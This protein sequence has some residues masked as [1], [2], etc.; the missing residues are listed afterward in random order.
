MTTDRASLAPKKARDTIG[1]TQE[2]FAN[3]KER[4]KTTSA[5][6]AQKNT[7][8]IGIGMTTKTSVRRRSAHPMKSGQ[9]K[10]VIVYAQAR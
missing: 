6:V 4:L 7:E 10:T 9:R 3:A 8:T 2:M 1:H 5:K